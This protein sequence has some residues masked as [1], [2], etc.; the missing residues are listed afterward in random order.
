MGVKLLSNV[1]MNN[2]IYHIYYHF[3]ILYKIEFLNSQYKR[4]INR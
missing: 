2:I 4:P 3:G 1:I